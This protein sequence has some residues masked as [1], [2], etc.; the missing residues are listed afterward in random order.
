MVSDGLA[1]R[2]IESKAR[3]HDRLGNLPEAIEAYEAL[4]TKAS[5]DGQTA[6]TATL[7]LADL[8]RREG[9]VS[10]AMKLLETCR[11]GNSRR[12]A[13]IFGSTTAAKQ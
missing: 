6:Q 13:S 7:A 1:L 11:T 5:P 12:I 10:T 9:N 8:W 2:L 4:R 3:A